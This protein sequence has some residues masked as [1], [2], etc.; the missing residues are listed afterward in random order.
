MKTTEEIIKYIAS[1][2]KKTPVK[3]YVN[4]KEEIEF[5]K[6]LEVYGEGKSKVIFADMKDWQEFFSGNEEKIDQFRLENKARN[7]A[8]PMKDLTNVNARIEP[9]V[10][11]REHVEIADNA[12]IM[13]GAVINIGAKI[14]KNTMI[15]MN[16]ILGGRAEVGENSHVGAG[17]VLS[18]VI[19]P[20]NAKPVKVGN[21]VLIGANAVILE[22]VQ[23]ADN[24]VVAAGSVVTKD[25]EAGAVVAGVPARVI[26][27]REEVANEKVDIIAELR[28]L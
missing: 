1:S 18:G 3:V 15:D 12:V 14:G 6:T 27:T 19:E 24:A 16:A 21:N 20:A 10:S 8:I 17:A 28:N 7:S 2:V 25:V 23:I 13:M 4:F 9:G 26:K 22:G 11:I 5:P